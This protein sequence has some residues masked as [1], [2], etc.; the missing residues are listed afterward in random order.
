MKKK[1]R[2]ITWNGSPLN[3][4]ILS[5][6]LIKVCSLSYKEICDV[7]KTDW[8]EAKTYDKGF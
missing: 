5:N 6:G 7:C 3:A 1:I 4:Y 2:I 8:N